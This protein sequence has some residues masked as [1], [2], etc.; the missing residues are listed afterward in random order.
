VRTRLLAIGLAVISAALVA[1]GGGGGGNGNPLPTTHPSAPPTATPTPAPTATP[2]PANFGCP[3]VSPFATGSRHAMAAP[4]PIG[5]GDSFSYSG[6]LQETYVQSA[7][8]PQPTATTNAQV[9]VAVSDTATTAPSG[10]SGSTSTAVET[11]AFP[12]HT[13]TTTTSQ[14]LELNNDKLLLYSTASSDGT[15]NSITT[16][17]ANAQEIDDLGAAGSWSNDSAAT[18]S[19]SISDGTAIS[20]SIASDGSYVDTETY[21]DGSKSTIGVNGT[22]DAKA[23]DGSGVY[24]FGGATFSYAAPSS[25]TITLTITSPGNPTKTRSFPAWFT[26]PASGHYITDS[27]VDN[28]AK[29][30]D[31]SCSSVPASIGT[32]GDQIVETYSVLDP[33][34]GYTETR[35]TTTY[36]VAG[37]GPACVVISDTL[38]SYYDYSN[39]TTRIDY[40]SEN[41][42]PNS[43]NTIAETLSVQS[44]ACGSGSAPCTQVRRADALQPVSPVAVAGRIAAI[45]HYRAVQR[46]QRVEAL[47]RFSLR[48]IH[49][50]A[51]R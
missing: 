10:N 41:G 50:G 32:S 39:D 49:Q 43:V 25:G 12:T 40:Q 6:S 29:T 17:Y 48:A 15:G 38:D 11:D 46:A 21:V 30:F 37:Y 19:E 47:H 8:C 33:V 5:S 16:S 1:C 51:V 42:Q 13:S 27:F 45:Q 9:S 26:P 20:R 3:G 44:A 14:V 31:S 22:A 24:S 18:M 36:D 7:P 2:T 28:G 35:T 34:L 4:R 23:L